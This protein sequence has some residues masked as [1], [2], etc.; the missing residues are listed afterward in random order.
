MRTDHK[1]IGVLYMCSALIFFLIG[2]T[3]AMVMRAQLSLPNLKLLTPDTYNQVFTMHG[4][5]MIFLVVMPVL[6]GFGIYLVPLMIGA[7]DMAF[8][9]LSATGFCLQV[10]G[11]LLL[12]LSF[13][14]GQAPSAGWFSYAPLSEKPFSPGPGLD[15]WA[16]SLL[17]IAAS[18]IAVTLAVLFL[19]GLCWSYLR[20]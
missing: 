2:G 14:T 19:L 16:V 9:R 6:M 3:E 8:P 17:L 11:G 5:T 4:T 12:Y 15:F 7:S 1:S 20:R 13:A 18:F 10:G